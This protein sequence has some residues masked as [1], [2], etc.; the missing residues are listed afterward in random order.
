MAQATN[1]EDSQS[2]TAATSAAD[3]E[4][5]FLPELPSPGEILA[6]SPPIPPEN[7]VNSRWASKEDYLTAQ[8]RILRC[9]A[10]EGLRNSVR[11]YIDATQCRPAESIMDDDSTCIYTRVR[12]RAVC[13]ARMG[14]IFTIEFSVE[15][16]PYRILW[17]QS[18]RLIPGAI[19]ALTPRQDNFRTVCKI[20]TIVQRPFRDGLDQNPP[21]VDIMFAEA[22][23]A[24][25]DPDLEM[26][27]IESREGYFESARHSLMGLQEAAV[28]D[29]P[30]DK[31]LLGVHTAD[32][33]P[34]FIRENPIMDLSSLDH[35]THNVHEAPSPI[36][37]LD[38]HDVINDGIPNIQDVTLLDES[39]LQA[40]HRA[41]TTELA[42]IQGPPG[43]G[44]TFVSMEFLKTCVGHRRRNGGPP[45]IVSATTNHALDQLLV[46][47]LEANITNVLRLGG[48][49]KSDEMKSH[50]L[51][52]RQILQRF[53]SN[54]NYDH[55]DRRR[56]HCIRRFRDVVE[57]VF[58]DRLISPGALK[59]AGIITQAQCDTLLDE[60]MESNSSM[61]D[62]G[63]FGVWLG[64]SLIQDELLRSRHLTQLE[65]SEA[66]A[67]KNLP[68]FEQEEVEN[69]ADDEEDQVRIRG[70]TFKLEHVWSGK[71]PA[72]MSRWRRAVDKALKGDDFFAIPQDLRGAVYQH[73]RSKLLEH[74]TRL[75]TAIL[76]EYVDVCKQ[77]KA[78][79]ITRDTYL[80]ENQGIDIV[81]CTTTGLTKYRSF[82]AAL[83]PK[84]LLIEEAAETR[85]VD[86]VSA[87]YPSVQQLILVGDH[88]Q[89][90][91]KCN[92]TWLAGH[93]FNAT[94]SLFQRMVNLNMPFR[95]LR[96][97]RRMKPELRYILSKFYP[98]LIDHPVVKSLESR[99]DVPG[100]G[101][102]N[103]W[104]FDH[105]WPE[106]MNADCS[107]FNR[108]EA[109]MIVHFY[110]YLVLN[111]TPASKITILT[112]YNGQCKVL[113]REL[114]RHPSLIGMEKE[115]TVRTID[116]YQ[117]EENDVVL[118]SLVRSPKEDAAWKVGFLEDE[119]RAVVAVSRARCGF[120]LFGNI[121]NVLN[122]HDV[123]FDLWAK[124]WNGF[125][126][127]ECVQRS[128][129]IPLVCQAHNNETWMKDVDDWG[130]NVGGCDK[131]C[132]QTRPC[133]HP[134]TL[135]CHA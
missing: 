64:E 112:Y 43:T 14:P 116:S 29:S 2:H 107:K 92:I 78:C 60:T 53:P 31:Y 104:L 82:L 37:G 126:E 57:D 54:T 9:D 128:K 4:W 113:L 19:V 110:A 30:L 122:A 84:S 86:I 98:D 119:H 111:G 115:L 40:L 47:C 118:L 34:S 50:T 42:I 36:E 91:P 132:S 69:I 83:E 25:I 3:Q 99:P 13:L 45:I 76:M 88:Q 123:S 89:L 59:K 103:C 80:V 52:Q 24:I 135:K 90:T 22:Q 102:R 81:G 18:R 27:M 61:K 125:A 21:R 106:E 95:M 51:Y 120:Y 68:E 8:Y 100:M 5:I 133:G 7:P 71:P 35:R 32:T 26:I 48:R 96:E 130:D 75:V 79:K 94:V 134:C 63:P 124:I 46:L 11:S 114:R 6:E 65:L 129:G 55:L 23:D 127:Q 38:N 77:L 121:Q 17:Q 67:L 131:Q 105:T 33:P 70:E 1:S 85:E 16:S 117:G 44:K 97:Q 56:K 62:H 49:T 66:E 28:T 12:V 58:G 10:V 109:Q 108:Q 72:D 41:I 74:T 39:Q 15:R 101:G 87:L 93:P 73:L 20:A